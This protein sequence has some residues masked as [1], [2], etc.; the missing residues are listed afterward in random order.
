MKN[1][2]AFTLIEL[3]IVISIIGILASVVLVSLIGARQKAKEAKLQAMASTLI[4]AATVDVSDGS[5]DQ[6]W[7]GFAVY[8]DDHVGRCT[9]RFSSNTEAAEI[10]IE[11]METIG[12]N[13]PSATVWEFWMGPMQRFNGTGWDTIANQRSVMVQMPYTSGPFSGGKAIYCANTLGQSNFNTVTCNH[14]DRVSPSY[15]YCTGC[16]RSDI[17]Q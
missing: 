14:S 11:I 7:G 2:K 10:C 1:K 4:K 12:E 5:A 3:L 16:Y 13:I 15:S 6:D 8:G 9:A 17:V